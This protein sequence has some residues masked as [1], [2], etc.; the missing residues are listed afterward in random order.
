MTISYSQVKY[1]GFVIL[2]IVFL[3][4]VLAFALVAFKE[5]SRCTFT[6]VLCATFTTMMYVAPLAALV[7][8]ALGILLGAIQFIVFLIYRN[9]TPAVMSE[10]EKQIDSRGINIQDINFKA[11]NVNSKKRTFSRV[12]IFPITRSQFFGPNKSDPIQEHEDDVEDS[13]VN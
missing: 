6:G 4:M 13:G 5:G 8:N 10:M 7:P 1:F 11:N 12:D 9:W 3:G 2:D